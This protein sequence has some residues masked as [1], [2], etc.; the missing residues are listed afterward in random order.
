RLEQVFRALTDGIWS[1][2][3]QSPGSSG[4]TNGKFALSTIRRNL[5]REYVR[6]LSSIVLAGTSNPY[7]DMYGYVVFSGRGNGSMPAD[8]RVLARLHLKE[9]NSRISKVLET[10]NLSID[11]T[12]RAHLDE[13]RHRIA[14]VLDANLDAQP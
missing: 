6:R 14:K 13:S 3:D 5:Q 2:L 8:A 4:D 11:D 10:S 9:I 1:D 12:S 7:G